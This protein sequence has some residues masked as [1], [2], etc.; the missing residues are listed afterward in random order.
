MNARSEGKWLYTNFFSLFYLG[1]Y[2]VLPSDGYGRALAIGYAIDLFLN[3]IPMMLCQI[4][5]NAEAGLDLTP[6]QSWAIILK[7]FM[8][9]SF[10]FELSLMTCEIYHTNKL[11]KL[12]V[13]GYEKPT[14]EKRRAKAW[15]QGSFSGIGSAAAFLLIV[16]AGLAA[17]KG[18]SCGAG[19][20]LELA[21]C[22]KCERD[23]C[24][25]CTSDSRTCSRCQLGYSVIDGKCRDCDSDSTRVICEQCDNGRCKA[26]AE[27][28]RLHNGACERCGNDI[29]D[30]CASCSANE[31]TGC[32]SGY[33][34]D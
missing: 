15:C 31:C 13:R 30:K 24:A 10:I 23:N 22:N 33:Y 34:L 9:L 12:E 1:F 5:T 26:C 16:I 18:R 8:F 4:W 14:E 29:D 11:Q 28:Y 20:A 25:E 3:L 27:G 2:R 17:T 32:I 7:V 21:V 6:V 19:H